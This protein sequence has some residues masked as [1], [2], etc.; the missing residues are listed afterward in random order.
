MFFL[1]FSS[2]K[3]VCELMSLSEFYL[4]YKEFIEK[5]LLICLIS[6]IIFLVRT[7]AKFGPDFLNA[8]LIWCQQG[9]KRKTFEN[10]SSGPEKKLDEADDVCE[11]ID[12]YF[13]N[14]AEDRDKVKSRENI[15]LSRG[16]V[17][18]EKAYKI[19]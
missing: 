18:R 3:E 11:E 15:E 13:E 19:F 9:R 5:L 16:S 12:D 7:K 4:Y 1:K 6:F 8:T 2:Q 10:S 14:N 17:N